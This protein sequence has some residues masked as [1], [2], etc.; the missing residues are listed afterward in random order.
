[1]SA[2]DDTDDDDDD[3]DHDDDHDDDA[4]TMTMVSDLHRHSAV[5]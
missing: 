4:M 1:M 3:D 5:D 2:D